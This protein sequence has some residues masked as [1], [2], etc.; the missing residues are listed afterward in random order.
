MTHS[1][2]CLSPGCG[3]MAYVRGLC[4]SHYT[5]AGRLVRRGQATW[6]EL[7]SRG[8]ARPKRTVEEARKRRREI[9]YRRRPGS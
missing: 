6:A 1:H 4:P 3:R 9:F 8:L 5:I 2:G 7:E